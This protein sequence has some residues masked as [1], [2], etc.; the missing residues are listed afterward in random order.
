MRFKKR[1]SLYH[2]IVYTPHTHVF[3]LDHVEKISIGMAARK[4]KAKA[5]VTYP[6]YSKRSWRPA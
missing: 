6:S 3:F 2:F 4:E 5:L 1:E